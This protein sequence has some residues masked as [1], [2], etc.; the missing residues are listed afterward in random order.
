MS[1][2]DADLYAPKRPRPQLV[3]EPPSPPPAS[4][5][6]ADLLNQCREFAE[7]HGYRLVLAGD[8]NDIQYVANSLHALRYLDLKK[9][10]SEMLGTERRDEM[11]AASLADLMAEWADK[12]KA[13][14]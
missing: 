11:T 13:P 10:A 3:V 14:Q 7:A 1:I 5:G 12:T 9:V 2:T 4:P 6:E 8:P